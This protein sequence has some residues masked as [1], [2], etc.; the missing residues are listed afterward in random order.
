M[1]FENKISQIR[2]AFHR[3]SREVLPIRD[4]VS[5]TWSSAIAESSDRATFDQSSPRETRRQVSHEQR[6]TA[7]WFHRRHFGDRRRHRS[8]HSCASSYAGH[9]VIYNTLSHAIRK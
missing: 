8:H 6:D 2:L 4:R 1:N 5:V 3:K 7:Q 9:E